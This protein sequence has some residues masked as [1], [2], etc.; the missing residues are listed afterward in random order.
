[1]HNDL[2]ACSWASLFDYNHFLEG[3]S[4]DT[5]I[6]LR[7][8]KCKTFFLTKNDYFGY[9]VVFYVNAEAQVKEDNI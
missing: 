2:K 7:C 4:V 6:E 8:I 3:V 5:D 9:S 1:M